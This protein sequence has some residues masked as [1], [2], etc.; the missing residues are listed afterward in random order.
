MGQSAQLGLAV[1]LHAPDRNSPG[2]QEAVQGLHDPAWLA[3]AL[4]VPVGQEKHCG[5]EVLLQDPDM[6]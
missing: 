1:P 6:K 2:P 4:K 5:D 3:V